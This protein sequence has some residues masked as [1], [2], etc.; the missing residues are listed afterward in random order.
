MYYQSH[1][2]IHNTKT[3]HILSFLL[4]SLGI[5]VWHSKAALVKLIQPCITRLL[6]RVGTITN[7]TDISTPVQ[8]ECGT[9]LNIV[10][11]PLKKVTIKK[12]FDIKVVGD[13]ALGHGKTWTR[14]LGIT[15]YFIRQNSRMLK[16]FFSDLF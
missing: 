8:M 1:G 7:S 15:G 13:T 12:M 14:K 9:S 11:C 5:L 10:N 4:R 6:Y 16:I 2:E 3:D